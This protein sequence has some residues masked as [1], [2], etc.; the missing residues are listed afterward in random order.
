MSSENSKYNYIVPKSTIG[1][2]IRR[3]RGLPVESPRDI[4]KKNREKFLA[5]K[6]SNC[7]C[8]GNKVRPKYI[9]VQDMNAHF[10]APKISC[11]YCDSSAGLFWPNQEDECIKAWEEKNNKQCIINIAQK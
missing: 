7:K 9:S 1:T 8:C 11:G 2:Y 10:E 6:V 5:T 4:E 3:R